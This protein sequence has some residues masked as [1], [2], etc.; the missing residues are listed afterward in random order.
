MQAPE[1]LCYNFN[2]YFYTLKIKPHKIIQ[3]VYHISVPHSRHPYTLYEPDFRLDRQ[4]LFLTQLHMKPQCFQSIHIK[5]QFS[6]SIAVHLHQL[7]DPINL[8]C[9][10]HIAGRIQG[11]NVCVYCVNCLEPWKMFIYLHWYYRPYSLLF[12]PL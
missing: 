3:Y 10:L 2:S 11:Y 1:C 9:T 6:C 12:M 4:K 7:Y 8:T 5:F